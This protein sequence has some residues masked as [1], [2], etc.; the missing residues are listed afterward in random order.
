MRSIL[1]IGL[2][3]KASTLEYYRYTGISADVERRGLGSS[4][5]E[6]ARAKR[7]EPPDAERNCDSDPKA[8][9]ASQI[10]PHREPGA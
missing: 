4:R 5:K 3:I 7:Q 1:E 9:T 8:G 10:H 2:K 6:L